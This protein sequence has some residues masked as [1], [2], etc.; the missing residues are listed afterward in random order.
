MAS[1]SSPTGFQERPYGTI[2]AFLRNFRF[3]AKNIFNSTNI[4]GFIASSTNVSEL[5]A[6]D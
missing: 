5:I 4:F 2:G 1:K 3:K 6:G